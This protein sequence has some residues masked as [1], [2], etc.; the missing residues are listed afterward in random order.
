MNYINTLRCTPGLAIWQRNYYEHIVR[1]E[2]SLNRIRECIL[3]N[4]LRWAYDREN[5][6]ATE[7]ESEE[8]W[9]T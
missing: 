3:T 4:P 7:T 8:A 2:E 9:L 1:N 5:P 6:D